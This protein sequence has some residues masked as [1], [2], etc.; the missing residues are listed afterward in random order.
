MSIGVSVGGIL[1]SLMLPAIVASLGVRGAFHLA[2]GASCVA[3]V[4]LPCAELWLFVLAMVLFVAGAT[5]F[6]VS[7]SLY[8]MNLL[9]RKS[10]TR[11]EPLRVLF[12]AASYCVG[13]LLRVY[14]GETFASWVPYAL[15]LAVVSFKINY[16]HL[17]GMAKV[18]VDR[19]RTGSN[20]LRH[21][22]Q[23][24]RQPRLRLPNCV[25]SL[26]M[27]GEFLHLCANFRG[28]GR[29]RQDHGRFH[30]IARCLDGADGNVMGQLG[31]ADRS[32]TIV[33][34]LLYRHWAS[35]CR[36][37]HRVGWPRPAR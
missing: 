19:A 2:T 27:L 17:L 29:V 16:Y 23:F 30:R 34:W 12:C 3:S 14:L 24:V 9:P 26:C 13:P 5:A 21:A 8:T 32:T 33:D 1:A 6:E 11:F 22:R 7:L 20:P 35:Q 4:V 36:H 10:L 25:L 28:V 37:C 31:S 18:K 15:T